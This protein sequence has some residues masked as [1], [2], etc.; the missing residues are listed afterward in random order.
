MANLLEKEPLWCQFPRQGTSANSLHRRVIP[1]GVAGLFLRAVCGAPAAARRDRGNQHSS[2]RLDEIA[3]IGLLLSVRCYLLA[4]RTDSAALKLNYPTGETPNTPA[5]PSSNGATPAETPTTP[6][7]PKP[8]V[9]PPAVKY[10]SLARTAK[11]SPL[12]PPASAAPAPDSASAAPQ[13]SPRPLP[14]PMPFQSSPAN[15]S[16]KKNS[17]PPVAT[18]K[19]QNTR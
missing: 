10:S 7:P 8:P 19:K 17:T 9:P 14:P 11:T 6:A 5:Q 16:S 18:R 3:S 15:G 2:Q 12:R 1:T 13:K 4:L